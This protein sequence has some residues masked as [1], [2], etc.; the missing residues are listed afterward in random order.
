V[1][2]VQR[3]MRVDPKTVPCRHISLRKPEEAPLLLPSTGEPPNWNVR[4]IL[5]VV[6]VFRRNMKDFA[7][8][9]FHSASAATETQKASREGG[10]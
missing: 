6:A 2:I 9:C 3:E 7:H 4:K 10:F 1:S 5:Y 8:S